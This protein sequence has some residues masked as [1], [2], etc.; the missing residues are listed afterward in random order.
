DTSS[1][2]YQESEYAENGQTSA[3]LDETGEHKTKYEYI[4]GTDIVRTTTLANGSKLSYGH[5][6][7]DI[8]TAITQST[9]EGEENS[10]QTAY[11]CGV[12]TEVRSGNNI[13]H[14]EY[15][16]KRRI[17]KVGMNGIESYQ[18]NQYTDNTTESGITGK[19]DKVITTNAKGET[20][21]SITDKTGNL[22][23]VLYGTTTLVAST[24]DSTNRLTSVTDNVDGTITYEYDSLDRV[25]KIKK[26][27]TELESYTYDDYGSISKK[28]ISNGVSHSYT[29][30]YADNASRELK[31]VEIGAENTIRYEKDC[32]GRIREKS[33]CA[34]TDSA[35]EKAP[36]IASEYY[37]YRKVGDHATNQIST[38]RYGDNKDSKF[39]IGDSLKYAYDEMGNITKIYENGVFVVGYRYDKLNR[40]VREDNKKVNKTY[41]FS[42]DGNGNLVSKSEC[43]YTIKEKEEL[44]EIR[45]YHYGYE[46]GTDKLLGY[47]GQ[48]LNVINDYD[49]I[50]NPLKW[51]KTNE[52][53]ITSEISGLSWS[54][55]R[56]LTG[57]DGTSFRYNGQGQR[58]AKTKNGKEIKFT[59][60]S[61]GNI[62]KQSNGLEFMYDNSGVS[63]IRYDNAY[64]SYRK[65]IFGNIIGILDKNGKIIVKY[66]YD[67]WG[68]NK[69]ES[70]ESENGLGELNPFR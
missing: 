61:N 51:F 49:K 26:G 63:G 19:V 42:Y 62:V 11:T 50:G 31:A 69:V 40:L 54:M 16:H 21:T 10:N 33:V 7:G 20:F 43:A 5:G 32:L 58:I 14:Y 15:D 46:A 28:M 22:R 1:K 12:A 4:E 3:E 47:N 41:V 24:Y 13:I 35:T 59:Y 8:V 38:I 9:E 34:G 2:F 56:R 45:T 67:A 65:D 18:S 68:K 39:V 57:F 23:K 30:K 53:G 29:Y 48:Y 52:Q 44:T 25:T 37:Y 70:D 6:A 17:T 60:D 36:R 55:G 64:Y 66:S 27:T